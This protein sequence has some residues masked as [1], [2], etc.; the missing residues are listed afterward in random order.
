[1][2][3][4]EIKM[5]N[6]KNIGYEIIINYKDIQEVFDIYYELLKECN[7][8]SSEIDPNKI[9]R[10]LNDKIQKIQENCI[11]EK[12]KIKDQLL[13]DFDSKF[14]PMIKEFCES[15]SKYITS[16]KILQDNQSLHLYENNT[17]KLLM[18]HYISEEQKNGWVNMILIL[19]NS[20]KF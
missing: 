4:D 10:L 12:D 20:I 19:K 7:D 14:T 11:E 3:G 2:E 6:T 1:M 5:R 18:D 15:F 8:D 13:K 17:N 16:K 9:N